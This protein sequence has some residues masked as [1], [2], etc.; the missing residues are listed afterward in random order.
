M[1]DQVRET[2]VTLD[3]GRTLRAYDT[4]R[5]P[6]DARTPIFWHHGTPNVGA[7]PAPL[8]AVAE[9]HGLR[10]VSYD[11]PGY[12]GSSP[13][14]GRNVASAASDVAAIADALGIGRFGAMGYSGGGAHAL[15]CAAVLGDRVFA[16]AS[17]SGVAPYP[18]RAAGNAAGRT[19]GNAAGGGLDE[20][21]W[22]A[23]MYPGN[24]IE[25]RA[26][27][28]GRP[29]LE[30]V[31]E[32][33]L[34]CGGFDPEMFAPADHTAFDG[35]W[36]WLRGVAGPV[37]LENGP[38][39]MIDDD[40][41]YTTGWGCDPADIAVPALIVHGADDRVVPVAHGRWLA[42]RIPGAELRV[43]PGDGHLSI[44]RHATAAVDW[45]GGHAPAGPRRAADVNLG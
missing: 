26:A 6:G 21:A 43:S 10:W 33:T 17:V 40:I 1:T 24:E 36:K 7:P 28:A 8:F 42:R 20:R 12:G 5:E 41:A 45:L 18:D 11:R 31:L 35:D 3:D 4:A 37:A 44:L 2:Y 34:R 15:A 23:G 19:A 30:K 14:P 9:R 25:L 38:G 39:G 22:Y 32:A 29:V 13:N 16:A 27:R